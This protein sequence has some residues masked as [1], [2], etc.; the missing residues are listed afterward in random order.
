MPE[1]GPVRSASESGHKEASDRL[2]TDR[3]TIHRIWKA[4]LAG[5]AI[6]LAVACYFLPILL[7]VIG[8]LI[9]SV[10]IGRLLYRARGR[11]VPTQY[12][13]DIGE[14]DPEYRTFIEDSLS[15][16]RRRRIRGHT[17]LWEAA[18]LPKQ[19]DPDSELLL[20]LGVWIGWSTRLTSDFS[21]RKVYGFDT[22]EGLVEDWLIE[23]QVLIK[24]GTFSLSDPLAKRV[25]RDTGVSLHDG[26]PTELG[27]DVQFIRGSTYETLAPFLADRP[28][29]PIRLF[30]MD[31][32]SYESCLHALET[33]KDRFTEGS[34]LVF[35]EYLI[36]NSEMRAFYEFQKRYGLEWRYRAWGLEI[37]EMNFAMVTARWKR[38]LYYLGTIG[39]YWLDGR[40]L[41]KF[42]RP[43]FWRF[44]LGAPLGDI[45]F[46]L[47]AAGQRQ[48]VSLEITG[49]GELNRNR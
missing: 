10:L 27:R 33:C 7:A 17:L 9:L 30:H 11:Y 14:Y 44:W 42:F 24:R 1:I 35:D 22:F 28:T 25:M 6:A 47:G 4:V 26:T 12:S 20:D 29:A 41:W 3:T 39:V 8:I 46:L 15:E 34:I 19:S 5:I 49:L 38:V 21:G 37:W 23:E 16:L 40:F 45:L 48:S 13:K 32:D 18:R 2:I 31:L 43:R 36:T